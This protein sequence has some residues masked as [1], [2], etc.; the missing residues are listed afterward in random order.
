MKTLLLFA[1]CGLILIACTAV[2]TDASDANHVTF[3]NSSGESIEQLTQKAN[4]Y[5]AQYGKTA[6]FK[7][8][9]SSLVAVFNC[10]FARQ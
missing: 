2:Y 3:L 9:D 7:S 6:S 1:A 4:A 8:T 10:N 5:C